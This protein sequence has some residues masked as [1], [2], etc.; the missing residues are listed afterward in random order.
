MSVSYTH[1]IVSIFVLDPRNQ[2]Q[3]QIPGRDLVGRK[4]QP[5]GAL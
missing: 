5:T 3:Q 4:G 2:G 1:L